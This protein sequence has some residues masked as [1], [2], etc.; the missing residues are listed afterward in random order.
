MLRRCP[1]CDCRRRGRGFFRRHA[2]RARILLVVSHGS[3]HRVRLYVLRW[4][5]PLC[6][7]TF[8]DY[9]AFALQAKR[10]TLP[11]IRRLVQDRLGAT[12][13]SY[14]RSVTELA[15]PLFYS[16]L[17]PVVSITTGKD[18]EA[19]PALAHTTLFRWV[20]ALGADRTS[21]QFSEGR[22]RRKTAGAR[23]RQRA[24]F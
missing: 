14:R 11:D 6:G 2:A 17:D 10:Y 20:Q 18:D 23:E 22:R 9:P 21:R 5:C 13:A 3:I 4:R 7:R 15:L 24:I 1:W 19:V 16:D 12:P 8:T